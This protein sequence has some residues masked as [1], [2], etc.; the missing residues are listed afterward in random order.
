MSRKPGIIFKINEGEYAIAYHRDQLK[1]FVLQDK[2]V[3]QLFKDESCSIPVT[4]VN[5]KPKKILK[6]IFL[7][8]KIGYV[9]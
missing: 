1:E 9:D 3:V 2:Y 6:S 5:G 7:L 8:T 4:D